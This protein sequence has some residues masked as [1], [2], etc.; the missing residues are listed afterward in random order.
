MQDSPSGGVIA[1]MNK[2][3]DER[4]DFCFWLIYTNMLALGFSKYSPASYSRR[5]RRKKK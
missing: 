3:G 5:G 4:V 1:V 2:E